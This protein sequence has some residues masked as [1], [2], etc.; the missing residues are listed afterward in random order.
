MRLEL[1]EKGA[2]NEDFLKAKSADTTV[3]L[4]TRHFGIVNGADLEC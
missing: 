2:A 4:E 3:P 1:P